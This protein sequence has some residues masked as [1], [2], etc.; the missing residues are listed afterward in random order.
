MKNRKLGVVS[1]HRK[2]MLRNLATSLILNGSITTTQ[3]RAMELK[4]VADK[5]VTFAK[6]ND[7]HSRRLA[8]NYLFNAE[9]NDGKTALQVLFDEIGPQYT[10]RQGGYTRVI[11]TVVRRGDAAPMA[12][13]EFV[14]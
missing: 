9:N 7:L 4:S 2:A 10:S 5:L 13:I 3:T 12:R 8:A 11:K 1:S 6:K 14:K